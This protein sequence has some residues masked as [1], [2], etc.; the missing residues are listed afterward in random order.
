ML[1]NNVNVLKVTELNTPKWLSGKFH[2]VYFTT[3]FK[4]GT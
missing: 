1:H 3:I 2:C 4:K